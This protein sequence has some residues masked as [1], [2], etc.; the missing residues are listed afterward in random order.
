MIGLI[1][2]NPAPLD[3]NYFVHT[4][5]HFRSRATLIIVPMNLVQQWYNEIKKHSSLNVFI[6]ST[7]AN[8]KKLTYGDVINAD[9]IIV[10]KSFLQNQKYITIGCVIFV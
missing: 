8:H 7:V 3:Q 6:V 5:S 9:V 4:I 1:L 10:S 2:A